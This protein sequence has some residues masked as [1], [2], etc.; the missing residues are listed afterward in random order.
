MPAPI[1][2]MQLLRCGYDGPDLVWGA[3]SDVTMVRCDKGVPQ[4][5]QWLMLAILNAPQ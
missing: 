4:C 2:S 1:D 5:S 3:R